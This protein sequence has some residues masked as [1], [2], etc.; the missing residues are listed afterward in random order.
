MD[1]S[2]GAAEPNGEVLSH[3][4]LPILA[5]VPLARRPMKP[6]GR[7]PIWV[8]KSMMVRSFSELRSRLSLSL[9]RT[10]RSTRE[11]VSG[12]ARWTSPSTVASRS[13]DFHWA[14]CRRPTPLSMTSLPS[15]SPRRIFGSPSPSASSGLL[16]MTSLAL[17]SP[18]AQP[19]HD[20]LTE[21]LASD[22]RPFGRTTSS[23]AC[24]V[25]EAGRLMALFTHGMSDRSISAA[26]SLA[27]VSSSP[28]LTFAS[29]SPW[30]TAAERL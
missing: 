24:S 11:A 27:E 1:G 7:L 20:H 22:A 13:C 8:V 30:K 17:P 29:S 12:C 26:L 6:S 4:T 14:P 2:D 25:P 9:K 5:R 15:K 3:S 10:Y 21:P 23:A 19:S 28:D 16:A 18:S